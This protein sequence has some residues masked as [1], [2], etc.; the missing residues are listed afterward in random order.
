MLV[1][2]FSNKSFAFAVEFVVHEKESGLHDKKAGNEP[3]QEKDE[4]D[5]SLVGSY[6]PHLL[7]QVEVGLGDCWMIRS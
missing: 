1:A 3:V 7:H 5:I 6:G 2:V 4:E